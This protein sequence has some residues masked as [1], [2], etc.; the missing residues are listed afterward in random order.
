MITCVFF[1]S[2]EE[3]KLFASTLDL[4]NNCLNLQLLLSGWGFTF[5]ITLTIFDIF[6]IINRFNSCISSQILF[7]HIT[8]SIEVIFNYP[9][10]KMFWLNKSYL[11]FFYYF[12]KKKVCKERWSPVKRDV[13]VDSVN[14]FVFKFH[15]QNIFQVFLAKLRA[16]KKIYIYWPFSRFSDPWRCTFLLMVDYCFSENLTKV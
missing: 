3:I 15:T 13:K 16:N 4:F 6:F 12:C 5:I 8:F 11:I 7:S 14:D 10:S 2:V 1:F 9:L